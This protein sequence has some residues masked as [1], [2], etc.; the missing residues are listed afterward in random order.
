M[1]SLAE[2][3]ALLCKSRSG[4]YKVMARDPTFPRP[5][6]DG[7]ARSAR[8][9]FAATEFAAWQQSKLDSRNPHTSNLVTPPPGEL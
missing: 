1:L 8:V 4:L 7:D 9:L 5:V 3:C 2:V 6:K